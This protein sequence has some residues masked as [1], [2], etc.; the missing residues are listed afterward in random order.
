MLYTSEC[1]RMHQI[2]CIIVK[3]FCGEGVPPPPPGP[4][5]GLGGPI[6]GQLGPLR[7]FFLAAGLIVVRQNNKY[8]GKEY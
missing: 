3:I 5:R 7:N 2:D 8:E 1:I 4:L 6:R